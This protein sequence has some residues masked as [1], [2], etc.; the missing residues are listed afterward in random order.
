MGAR[1]IRI[2]RFRRALVRPTSSVMIL[3]TV[4]FKLTKSSAWLDTGV[5]AA[6]IIIIRTNLLRRSG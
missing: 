5:R 1:Q 3:R 2:E 6:S 4:Q